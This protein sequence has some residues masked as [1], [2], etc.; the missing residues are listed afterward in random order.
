M[1]HNC[2]SVV[3]ACTDGTTG[4]SRANT[5]IFSRFAVVQQINGAWYVMFQVCER[6]KHQ[7]RK[8][9]RCRIWRC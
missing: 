3:F 8:Q 1:L 2:D 6:R 9:Q 5:I 4:Q 7:V